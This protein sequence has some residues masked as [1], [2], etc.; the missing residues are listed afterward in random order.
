MEM[1]KE[2]ALQRWKKL[3]ADKRRVE[4]EMDEWLASRQVRQTAIA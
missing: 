4:K 1:T 3:I 2:L